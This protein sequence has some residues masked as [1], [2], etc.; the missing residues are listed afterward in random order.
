MISNKNINTKI[1]FKLFHE[2]LGGGLYL[3]TFLS[4]LAAIVESIGITTVL[5]LLAFIISGDL[6]SSSSMIEDILIS[7]F[8]FIGINFEPINL[9]IFI[10][11]AFLIKGL[12]NFIT[13]GLNAYLRSQLMAKLKANLIEHVNSMQYESFVK[14]DSGAFVNLINEQVTRA[15]KCFYH[16]C[17]LMGQIGNTII[18]ISFG[19]ATSFIFGIMAG[20]IGMTLLFLFKKLNSQVRDASINTAEENGNLSS[21]VIDL[22]QNLKYFKVSNKETFLDLSIKKS[23]ELLGKFQLKSGLA[24]A[25]SQAIR[26]PV[27]FVLVIIGFIISYKFFSLN[28]EVVFVSMLF[29]Y[30]ALNSILGIQGNYQ[31]YLENIGSLTMIRDELYTNQNKQIISKKNYKNEYNFNYKFSIEFENITYTYKRDNDLIFSKPLNFKIENNSHV[32][33]VGKSGVGKTTIL[34]LISGVLTPIQG[35]ILW[36]GSNIHPS[37]TDIRIGYISQEFPIFNTS[38]RENITLMSKNINNDFLF[39]CIE[40]VSLNDLV[41]NLPN[42]LDTH[43]GERGISISGGQRQR[44]VIARE[45]YK[46]PNILL[47]DEATSSLDN[48][49]E[50]VV[51]DSI[52]KL[53]SSISIISVAHRIQTL[54]YVDKIYV[55]KDGEIIESGNFDELSKNSNN[56]F[57]ELYSMNKI[58]GK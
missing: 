29:F 28:I 35:S 9:L 4:I 25:L 41:K 16:L 22:V 14:K 54:E 18:Y 23:I 3:I 24:I 10:I 45:L 52:K 17:H 20:I 5:S 36:Y 37:N 31:Q 43:L 30:R 50:R 27:I 38:L 33:F 32:A 39:E 15:L 2:W 1:A 11:S 13:F 58:E 34:D 26:E 21:Q 47:M 6:S 46:K 49:T 7:V 19:L 44:L 8:K 55:L 51:R 48:L 42:G 12:I 40:A 57:N 56:Y 53:Q